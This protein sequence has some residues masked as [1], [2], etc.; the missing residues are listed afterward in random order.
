MKRHNY[1]HL[2]PVILDKFKK[3]FRKRVFRLVYEGYVRL[4]KQGKDY[5]KMIEEGISHDLAEEIENFLEGDKS[6]R[7]VEKFSVQCERPISPHGEIGRKRPRLDIHIRSGEK[8]ICP[9]FVFEAKRLRHDG[10]EPTDYFGDEGMKCF[11]NET[12]YPV[13]VFHEA[14]M[15]AYVQDKDVAHWTDWLKKHLEKR[16]NSLHVCKGTDWEPAVQI[17][18]LQHT[19]CT[20][21]LPNDKGELTVVFH[22]LLLFC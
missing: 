18:E 17:K 19:F 11:W 12:G 4:S 1:D 8:P 13:N 9:K 5:V 22:L 10:T 21:H 6:P 15:L 2:N 7:W 20:R 16:R 14:G 3:T